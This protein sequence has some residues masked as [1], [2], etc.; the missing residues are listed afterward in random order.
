MEIYKFPRLTS[1]RIVNMLYEITLQRE[2]VLT[3]VYPVDE[4]AVVKGE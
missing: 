1:V 2:T 4:E 3:A